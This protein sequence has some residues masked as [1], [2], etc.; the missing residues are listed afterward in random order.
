MQGTQSDNSPIE[1]L[2]ASKKFWMSNLI[3]EIRPV[4]L[5]KKVFEYGEKLNL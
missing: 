5:V 1:N 4:V 2:S 3:E